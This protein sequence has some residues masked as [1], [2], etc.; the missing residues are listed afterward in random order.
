MFDFVNYGADKLILM[1]LVMIR[2]SGVFVTAPVYG[3]RGIPT[4]IKVGL[5]VLLSLI[6]LPV[7]GG[8]ETLPKVQNLWQLTGL[9]FNELLVG[10]L[11]GLV[12]RFIFIGV[13]SGGAIVGYQAGFSF[14]NIFD[15]NQS[16][17]VSIIGRFW[18]VLAVLFFLTI[19]GHHVIIRA[20][21]DSYQVIPAGNA[22]LSGTA[23]DLFIKYSAYIFVIA[24]KIA[25]P[26]IITL[27]L[28]DIALGTVAKT[29]PTMNVFFVGFPIKIGAG[30]L[31]MALSL[32]LFTY[33]IQR[34]LEYLDNELHTLLIALGKA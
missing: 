7:I 29:M 21:V 17:Q 18:Y 32:P 10:V 24:I 13:L 2:A 28:T 9:V 26:V 20:F 3:D 30:L 22:H 6:L 31:V 33:V 4:I 5:V 16:D 25:S 1:L 34:S 11:I 8:L 23:A 15:P 19:N 12:Y 14:A 27:F